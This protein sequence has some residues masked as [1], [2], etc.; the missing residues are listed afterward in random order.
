MEYLEKGLNLSPEDPYINFIAGD[1]QFDNGFVVLD[2][3]TFD[4][5]KK[6]RFQKDLS[7][8]SFENAKISFEKT[9]ANIENKSYKNPLAESIFILGTKYTTTV[10]L[11]DTK[12]EL[13]FLYKDKRDRKTAKKYL[14][15]ALEHYTTAISM[16]PSQKEVEKIEFDRDL[17]LYSPAE[18]YFIRGDIYSW[19]DK[20]KKACSDWKVSKKLGN[21]DAR[22]SMREYK[23]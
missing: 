8:K 1:I 9:L 2:G 7:L 15:E 17:D 22:N 5:S 3:N 13:Y 6:S 16:A 11:G 21:E 4:L 18:L 20:W 12:F 10:I 19:M 23:C 14:E